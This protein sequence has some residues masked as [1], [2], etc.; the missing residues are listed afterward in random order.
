MV[1][2]EFDDSMGGTGEVDAASAS[3]LHQR[4][5]G[6]SVRLSGRGLHSG[7][8]VTVVIH[9]A[10]ENTGIVFSQEKDTIR[11]LASNVVDTS[12]GTTI[13]FN[14]TRISTIE[15]LMAALRGR[16]V[17]NALIEV[18][19][20]ETPALDG[21]ALPYVEAIESV[22]LV[23]L[24]AYREPIRLS[25]PVCVRRNGSFVLAVPAPYL[26]ITYVMNYDH[27]MIGSQTSTYVLSDSDFGDEIAPA[28]TFVLYEEVAELL[29]NKLARGGSLDNVIVVW[30]DR[31]SSKL[32]F[33]DELARHK[34]MDLVGDL[35]LIGG[36]LQAEVLAVKSGHALNVEFA[37]EVE[38]SSAWHRLPGEGLKLQFAG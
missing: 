29:G 30:Q 10:R 27:P 12:R 6:S 24:D 23:E 9:P 26:R 7:G 5:V 33:P 17:D 14:G 37:R 15:H 36:L 19:G 4:T 35:S 1:T 21:S 20:S 25:E 2:F 32:R 16:G 22:G 13:G 18:S 28:R 38:R 8:D 3:P 11:G 34:V 31:I